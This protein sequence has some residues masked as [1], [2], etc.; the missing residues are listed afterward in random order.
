MTNYKGEIVVD[1]NKK[2]ETRSGVPVE[3][4]ST[5]GKGDHSVHGVV[6][7]PDRDMLV[8]WT[9]KGCYR[10]WDAKC[11]HDLDLVEVWEPQDKEMVEAQK[12]LED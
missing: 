4:Y 12:N 9:N 6:K 7:Y 5:T 8:S 2:W 3:I 10:G 11:D 1:K